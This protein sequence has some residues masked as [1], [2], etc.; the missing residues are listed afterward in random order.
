M[1]FFLTSKYR[2]P[3]RSLTH[4]LPDCAV[5]ALMKILPAGSIF[6]S[7]GDFWLSELFLRRYDI[8]LAL[9]RLGEVFMHA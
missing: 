6:I 2:Q 5:R 3:F 1:I 7:A 8:K 4:S 9:Q